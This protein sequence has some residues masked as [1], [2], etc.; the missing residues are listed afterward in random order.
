[1]ADK[2]GY[3]TNTWA[4]EIDPAEEHVVANIA[5]RHGFSII[6][7]IGDLPGHYHFRHD[8]VDE[9]N[10]EHNRDKTDRLL[11][12]KEVKWA[13]Q[14]KILH[15]VKRDGIPTDPKF[16][17]MWYLLNEGQTGGPVGVDINVLPVWRK[18]ISGKGVV[19]SILDDGVDHTH[20]DLAGN[21]D[22]RASH[23]FNDNDGDPMPRDLD[24]D[25][26]HGTRCAGEVAAI[27]NNSICGTGVAYSAHVGG[28]R[29]LDGK[30]TDAL[31]AS[32]LGFQLQYV[33][34]FSNCWGPKDDGKTFGKPGP[35]A[36]KALKRGAETGRGGKGNV[37]VWA[38]GN[39]GLTDDDC[40]CDGY[41]T[42]IYTVSIGC[43]GDHGLS[44]Y[45]TELCSSTIA[46]T[47]N[48]GAHRE[49]EENKMITT[50]LHHQCTEQFKGTS[51][52]APLAAGMIALM[53]ES[54]NRLT[55][56]DVQHIIVRTAKLTSPVDDGWRTNGA[57][58][59]FN[60]KFGFGRLDADA[61]VE[62]AK[63]WTNVPA[64]RICTGAASIEERDIPSGGALELSIP[65]K[66]C[67]GT[68][69]EINKVEHVVLTISF[70]HRRRGD[71]SILLM[72]PS[73]TK[74]EMLSTRHYDD[75]KEGLDNWGFM[76]VH[77]WGENP[78]GF[79]QL[80]LIDNPLNAIGDR[81]LNG[82]GTL[83]LDTSKQDTDVEDLEEQVIDDQTKQQQSKIQQMKLQNGHVDFPY[84]PGVRRDEVRHQNSSEM[85][86]QSVIDD[87]YNLTE[88]D[89]AST[90]E[91]IYD[92]S[93]ISHP[94]GSGSGEIS[95]SGEEYPKNNIYDDGKYGLRA[96]VSADREISSSE[97]F[98]EDDDDNNIEADERDNILYPD[99]EGSESDR[100]FREEVPDIDDDYLD[101]GVVENYDDLDDDTLV[102]KPAIK[103]AKFKGANQKK[104]PM[105]KKSVL[106]DNNSYPIKK[107]V[108]VASEET[109][110]QRVQ[111]NAGYENPEIPCLGSGCSGVLLK[112]VL[113]FYGTEN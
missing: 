15:R 77:C 92:R 91:Y 68:V 17:E 105:A 5:K 67:A 110:T 103:K 31:E 2:E 84:P 47:F 76:T 98:D 100:T 109:A 96:E 26:C 82:Y 53:L 61:M 35:L 64:Q 11:L 21:F 71:V 73:G 111:V 9:L 60:H 88:S 65:T 87:L 30:A 25:N 34:I 28:V 37:Y 49:K 38:T 79:W 83:H 99:P 13:E 66:A 101:D 55:W 78:R 63:S 10:K 40:N 20:P 14:Q 3:F 50:D 59:H 4:V 42:S 43:I 39:G 33:D 94:Q 75:S 1:M 7:Q 24:P 19:V 102:K 86:E 16:K 32:S 44:A 90:T 29:M 52:A 74:N 51:S 18:G 93:H 107:K 95:G 70:I 57:G 112:W 80:K 27:A 56:R 46:V 36:A 62:M 106:E 23:D 108:Q 89:V 81:V 113:T 69:A 6:G 58:F 97:D 85:S 48:G 41:T 12:E 104:L 72:S 8:E 54:N 45:Y 22:P